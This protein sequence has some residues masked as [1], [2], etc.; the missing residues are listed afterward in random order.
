M[1]RSKKDGRRGGNHRFSKDYGASGLEN[2]K[3]GAG[4]VDFAGASER[5]FFKKKV[6]KER[7]KKSREIGFEEGEKDLQTHRLAQL[8]MPTLDYRVY[9]DIIDAL[10]Q[11]ETPDHLLK[12]LVDIAYKSDLLEDNTYINGLIAFAEDNENWIRALETWHVETG[13]RDEQ[14]SELSR[15][16]F[17]SYDVPRFMDNA[18]LDGNP[19]RQNWFKHIGG[20]QNIRTAPRLPFALTKRM[21]HHFLTAPKDYTIEEALRWGQVHALGGNQ[22]LADA[23]RGTYLVRILNRHTP[24]CDFWFTEDDFWISVIRFFIAHPM[25]DVYHVGRIIDY[26]RHQKYGDPQR[27]IQ[28]ELPN[29][30]MNRRTPERLLNQTE[31]WHQELQRRE[32]RAQRLREERAQGYQRR[33][34]APKEKEP[35]Q[36]EPSGI[37]ELRF[38]IDKT[39]WHIRELLNATDLKTEGSVMHHCAGTYVDS[40][41]EGRTSMWTMKPVSFDPM[42]NKPGESKGVTIAVNLPSKIISEVRGSR[43]RYPTNE[44]KH[45]LELWAEKEGLRISSYIM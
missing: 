4:W 9:A 19:T 18:W 23:L 3:P 37:G 40:C 11:S 24:P 6:S 25:L 32:E 34:D 26:I 44:E 8:E 5:R 31:A 43:N 35:F 45:I 12:F 39:P 15:H 22:N 1:S 14:F 41:H 21:A 20:G 28:P 38:T 7:R 2:G 27:N 17:A 13:D 42:V 29:F 36:W 10:E 33:R 16:L 30:S